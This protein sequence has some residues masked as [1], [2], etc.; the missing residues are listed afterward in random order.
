MDDAVGVYASAY[1][2]VQ[3]VLQLSGV[4]ARRDRTGCRRRAVIHRCVEP[5]A[6]AVAAARHL[7]LEPYRLAMDH[8]VVSVED[9][10]IDPHV[11]LV[12]EIPHPRGDGQA[13]PEIATD[14]RPARRCWED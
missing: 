1:L 2:V 12:C 4:G 7:P 6:I 8:D 5:E 14:P 11:L 10:E 13:G 3:T 9:V